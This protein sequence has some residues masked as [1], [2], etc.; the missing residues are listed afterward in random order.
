[1]SIGLL[2][3]LVVI[4]LGSG[5]GPLRPETY[6]LYV[7][8][9]DAGG[10][11]VGSPVEV[12]GAPAGQV[13]DVTILPPATNGAPGVADT[14]GRAAPLSSERDIRI[15]LSIEERFQGH[16]TTS[17]RA[18][19]ASLGM[20]GERYVKIVAGDVRQPT[21]EPGST[22]P[23]V[24]SVDL[25]LVLARIG[26]AANEIQEIAFLGT[27]LQGKI[28]S[29]AGT[30]GKLV[31]LESPLYDRV[32][33]FEDRAQSLLDAL[34]GGAGLVPQWKANGRFKANVEA[35]RADVSALS[36]STAGLD[37]W[38][39]PVEL[40]QAI[41]GLRTE[42]AALSRKL[43]AGQGTLGRLLH[44]E[45]LFVQLRVLRQ[46]LSDMMTAIQE[47]PAGSVNIELF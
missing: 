31:D 47:D 26:R 25:D 28:A 4:V 23:I 3:L 37:Q 45:E 14:S 13:V 29:G 19:L 30:A 39:D 38:S 2:A 33:R 36:D 6:T 9:D 32:D 8:L 40:R 5:R 15:E 34:D 11:R 44:D 17:S 35:L 21:L 18:Q 27:E 1:T 24:A 42:V 43:D 22:I 16:V 10:L 7:N 41:E 46:G 12:G 20:G